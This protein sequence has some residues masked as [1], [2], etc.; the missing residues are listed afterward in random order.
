M[1]VDIESSKIQAAE[2]AVCSIGFR[3]FKDLT[4]VAIIL[5]YAIDRDIIVTTLQ[6]YFFTM[7]FQIRGRITHLVL[8][9]ITFFLSSI[10]F[11]RV[12]GFEV[13]LYW[14]CHVTN[15]RRGA[16]CVIFVRFEDAIAAT[17]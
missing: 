16:H 13:D 9:T 6:V 7:C 3:L 1:S 11:L 4:F 10:D 2:W 14:E 8:H 12:E 17:R 15:H 5:L